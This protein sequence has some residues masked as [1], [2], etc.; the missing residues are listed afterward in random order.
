M[1]RFIKKDRLF[2]HKEYKPVGLSGLKDEEKPNLSIPVE[3]DGSYWR[4]VD[5]LIL[6]FIPDSEY[7]IK[8]Q[9]NVKMANE[10]EAKISKNITKTKK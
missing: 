4:T 6:C 10:N 5:N 1:F 3:W 8:A 2:L 7:E 9:E